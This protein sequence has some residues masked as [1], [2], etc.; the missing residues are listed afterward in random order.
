ME[1]GLI[2]LVVILFGVAGYFL[3]FYFGKRSHNK[4]K[5]KKEIIEILVDTDQAEAR[6]REL[7]KS[8]IHLQLELA[9]NKK[10]EDLMFI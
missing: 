7:R 5:P 4:R 9:R 8:I 2:A 10:P 6:L 3:G 1:D